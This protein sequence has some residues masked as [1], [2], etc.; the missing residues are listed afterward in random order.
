MAL[1]LDSEASFAGHAVSVG[2]FTVVFECEDSVPAVQSRMPAPLQDQPLHHVAGQGCHRP[3]EASGAPA[4][5]PGA[6]GQRRSSDPMLDVCAPPLGLSKLHSRIANA[7]G[8]NGSMG[9]RLGRFT[10]VC[11][12]EESEEQLQ[13]VA[14]RGVDRPDE[15]IGACAGRLNAALG[16]NVRGPDI[17]S[18]ANGLSK[19]QTNGHGPSNR[20]ATKVGRFTVVSVC[21]DSAPAAPLIMLTPNQ[22]EP[23]VSL[24]GHG[25]RHLGEAIGASAGRLCA[26]ARYVSSGPMFDV[27]GFD[28]GLSTGQRLPASNRSRNDECVIRVGRFTVNWACEGSAPA[29]PLQMP[30]PLHDQQLC[31]AAVRGCPHDGEAHGLSSGVVS[32]PACDAVDDDVGS[33][34]SLLSFASGRPNRQN[35]G[36]LRH[37]PEES[38]FGHL[39]PG[40]RC[41]WPDKASVAPGTRKAAVRCRFRTSRR[42]SRHRLTIRLG[43][44]AK[45]CECEGSAQ[46]AS[47]RIPPHL[48]AQSVYASDR[49]SRHD[50]GANSALPVAGGGL[51]CDYCGLQ[52]AND[53]LPCASRH[54]PNDRRA[55]KA[56]CRGLPGRGF[57]ARGGVGHAANSMITLLGKIAAASGSPAERPLTPERDSSVPCDRFSFDL[58]RW[59]NSV[60]V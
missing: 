24:V 18:L 2:R 8:P 10:V 11:E 36:R 47:L 6:A 39:A 31:H 43:R 53:Q 44:L 54:R 23:L 17:D 33:S 58:D 4:S 37:L 48:H 55:V 52:R 15:S 42:P 26:A 49:G 22:E 60:F 50:G 12:R 14:C 57:G 40:S 5:A 9:I 13:D 51:A 30:M 56:C 35:A 41:H 28:V 34:K 45:I 27:G 3:G 16:C 1:Q 25:C 46:A 21:E 59:S 7:E 38:E 19:L 32:S 20:C 29:V